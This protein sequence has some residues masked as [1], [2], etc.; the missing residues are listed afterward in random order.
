MCA[1]VW[2]GMSARSRLEEEGDNH[3]RLLKQTCTFTK[4]DVSKQRT[5]FD[6]FEHVSLGMPACV[7]QTLPV[8]TSQ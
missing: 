1:D 6:V 2:F 4:T 5:V 3:A 7:G 8:V